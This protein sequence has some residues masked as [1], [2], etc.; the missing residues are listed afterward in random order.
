MRWGSIKEIV[1]GLFALFAPWEVV[2]NTYIFG[3]LEPYN[4][5]I[6]LQYIPRLYYSR[7]LI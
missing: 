4:T 5:S 7:I 1:A 2:R 3:C 6:L